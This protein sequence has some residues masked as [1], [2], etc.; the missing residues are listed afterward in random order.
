MTTDKSTSTGATK[1]RKKT[2]TTEATQMK[3][4]SSYIDTLIK[5]HQKATSAI[6]ETRQRRIRL[7]NALFDDAMKS[8]KHALEL[9]KK[10]GEQPTAYK[11]NVTAIMESLTQAQ[12][13]ALSLSKLLVAEQADM[14]DEFIKATKAFIDGS[15]EST[16]AAI[17]AAKSWSAENPVADILKQSYDSMKMTAA[18]MTATA[19]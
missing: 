7:S 5:N 16:K 14:R 4:T 18:K 8:Q 12:A 3:E 17:S 1:T 10:I 2:A 9:A 13:Q 15:Q 6:S 11:D 19:A